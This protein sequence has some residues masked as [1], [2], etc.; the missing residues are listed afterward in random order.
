M[1]VYERLGVR[2]V[3]SLAGTWTRVGGALME[4]ETTDAMAEAAKESVRLDELQA[5]A[6]NIIAN[7]TGAQAGYV[8]SG[9]AAALTLGTAACLT[10]LDVARMNRLPDTS[11]MPNEVLMEYH[12]RCGFDHAIRAAGAKI[13]TTSPT[14]TYITKAQEF[15]AAITEHTVAIAYYYQP[16]ST[17]PLEQVIDIGNKYRIPVMVDAAGQVPPV[18]NLRKFISMGAALVAYSG[19]KGIRGPQNSGILCGRRELIAA[20][21]LQ[22]LEMPAGVPFDIWDPPP[23]LI[24]KAKLRGIPQNGIGRSMK[25][26]KEAIVGLLTA[27]QLLTEERSTKELKRQRL[28]LEHIAARLQDVPGV[29]TDLGERV[30]GGHP[31]LKLKLDELKLGR[32]AFEMAQ[33]LKAGDPP[34]CFVE[35]FPLGGTLTILAVNLDEERANIVGQYLYR[36]VTS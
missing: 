29:E 24:P 8:T 18:E 23:S 1:Q 36:A 30:L 11:G 14:K 15:E 33:R 22:N 6:S 7:I 34:I 4:Q 25:V 26:S 21:A 10:G 16:E 2:A 27:L 19:G 13:V 5:A 31:R 17:P 12:Q 35:E 32:N 28:L 20:A 3:I 9:A